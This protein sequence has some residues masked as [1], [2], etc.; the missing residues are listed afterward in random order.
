MNFTRNIP[1]LTPYDLVVC[2]A[3]PSGCAAALAARRA[4]LSVLLLEGQPQLG[5]MATSGLVSHWLGGRTQEGEWVVGGL[6][7]TLVEKAAVRGCAVIPRMPPGR[8]YQPH[9]WLPWFIHGIPIDPFAM[10]SFLDSKLS[11]AGVNLLYETRAIDT[12][13]RDSRITHVIVQNKSGLQAIPAAAV[14]DATGDADVAALSGCDVLAGREEDGLM[15]PASLTFHLYGVDHRRLSAEIENTQSPKFREKIAELR[16][17]GVWPFPY[18]IF[19]SVKLVQED[20]AMI[21]TMRLPR[22]NGLDASSR[23]RA[24]IEGRREAYALLDLFRKHFPGFEHAGMKCIAPLL[25]IRET[26]RI[27][28]AFCLTVK[29]LTEGRAFDDTV[30]FS[31]YGW[32][33]PDPHRP[34][35]QPLVDESEGKFI[36]KVEKVLYTP[37][38]YRIMVPQPIRNL[39]CPGRAVGVERDVLGP[40][41]VMA[42]CMA[43]GEACG[44]AAVRI[45]R[46]GVPAAA[47]DTARLRDRLREAGARVD[48]QGLPP[49]SPRQDP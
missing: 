8:T 1:V 23:T 28:S 38:P 27:R 22:V 6:F 14:I 46:D 21:N 18:D 25:G 2:G 43:M 41:R 11:D 15:A 34:S 19:I 12:A 31:M 40:L 48:R 3:G 7:R 20:V 29:D 47:V 42:P 36:N 30:G 33:L 32:D 9:G 44:E 24:L 5:G 39:L 45:V 35:L 49:I 37:I 26:R 4:G 13:V 10:A 17:Q 16:Q